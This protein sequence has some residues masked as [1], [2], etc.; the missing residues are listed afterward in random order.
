M[1]FE[2]KINFVLKF[3]DK[4][5]LIIKNSSETDVLY[6]F[7]EIE[8]ALYSQICFEHYFNNTIPNN[9]YLNDSKQHLV[10]SAYAN[11]AYAIAKQWCD[12]HGH[13]LSDDSSGSSVLKIL[14]ESKV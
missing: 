8:S 5:D 2:D 1:S 10:N 6:V 9:T 7:S 14:K 3:S 13:D 12:F 4:F 11:S